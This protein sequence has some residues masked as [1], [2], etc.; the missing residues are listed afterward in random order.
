[1]ALE[2]A[3]LRERHRACRERTIEEEVV[4]DPHREYEGPTGREESC[5]MLDGARR[6]LRI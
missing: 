3:Q 1:M 2:R 5:Q 4:A 6:A